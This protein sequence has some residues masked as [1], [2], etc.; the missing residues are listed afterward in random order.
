MVNYLIT[1]LLM[2][3]VISIFLTIRSQIKGTDLNVIKDYISWFFCL[4]IYSVL[5]TWIFVLPIIG[6]INLAKIENC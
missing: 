3:A 2:V 6:I 5:F 4:L 1:T